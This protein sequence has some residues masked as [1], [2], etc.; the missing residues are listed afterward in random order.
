MSKVK[1]NVV[2]LTG[3]SSGIG[4]AMAY[5]LD[6]K[7]A[8]VILSA[9]RKEELERVKGNCIHQDNIKILTL[10]LGDSFSIPQKAKEA[11]TFFG[12]IDILINNGGISQRDKVINTDLEVDRMIMEVNYFG[13]IGLSK[14][15]L[16]KMVERQRGHHVV[17]SSAVGIISTPLRSSY[18]A[19]KHA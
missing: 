3:A 17:I 8:K 11:E 13:T 15:L 10:D 5:L 9:R 18:A 14:A 2:W 7:E 1:D 6:K 4:E 16:P 19:A 12:P